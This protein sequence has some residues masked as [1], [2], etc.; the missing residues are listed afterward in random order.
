MRYYEV[1]KFQRDMGYVLFCCILAKNE[2]KADEL[3]RRLTHDPYADLAV[4]PVNATV[5][6]RRYV[7]G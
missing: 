7:I 4:R 5:S 2:K 3:V 1:R 6:T